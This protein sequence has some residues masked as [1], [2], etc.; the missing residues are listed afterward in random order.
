MVNVT[1]S[2]LVLSLLVGAPAFAASQ[3]TVGVKIAELRIKPDDGAFSR[4]KIPGGREVAVLGKSDDGQWIK[5]RTQ[6]E[7]GEDVI[8]LEGWLQAT[9]LKGADPSSLSVAQGGETSK[10]SSSSG[11][12]A[13][14]DSSSSSDSFGDTSS[15]GDSWGDSS[16]SSAP[17]SSG[18]S[19]SDPAPAAAP[20]TEAWDAAPAT[21][22]ESS[23]SGDAWGDSSNS[24]SDS[25]SSDSAWDSGSESSPDAGSSSEESSSSD[26]SGW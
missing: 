8:K 17:A 13:W 20:T 18:D 19:W 22:S 26:D 14:G 4:L 7:R 10:G 9:Q 3:A 25:S 16:A 1:R 11:A 6:I 15:S 24:S 23:S 21:A 5:V 12:G 2:L